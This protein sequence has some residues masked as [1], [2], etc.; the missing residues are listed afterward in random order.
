M[1]KLLKNITAFNNSPIIGKASAEIIKKGLEVFKDLPGFAS[2]AYFYL[3]PEDFDFSFG[4]SSGISEKESDKIF[5]NLVDDGGITQVINSGEI[6]NLESEIEKGE[7]TNHLVIPLIAASGIISL[8]L[9]QLE[10]PLTDTLTIDLCRMHAN[11]L[12][13]LLENKDLK[14]EAD[15]LKEITEQQVALKTKDIAQSTRELKIILDSVQAGIII[16]DKKKDLII[17][18]NMAASRLIGAGKEQIVGTPRKNYFF[19]IE[20]KSI[21]NKKYLDQ[22][23]LLK[24]YDGNLIPIIRTIKDIDA[25]NMKYTIES[26]MDISER[27]RMEDALSEARFELEQR[28]EERTQELLQVNND[29]QKE[30]NDRK[31]AEEQLLKLYWAVEQ[32]PI[33][34]IIT[35]LNGKIEYVNSH[36]SKM[37]Q[38]KFKDTMGNSFQKLNFSKNYENLNNEIWKK[39]AKGIEWRGEF[40]TRKK[41]GEPLWVSASASPIRNTEDK[42][43]HYLIVQ[44]D[45]SERK[46]VEQELLTAKEKAEQSD[47]LKSALLANMSHE[48][49]TPLIGILGFSQIL[50][51]QVEDKEQNE[52]VKEI[53]ISGKRLLNTLNGVLTISELETAEVSAE[54]VKTDLV[55]L[56]K[57]G[58]ESYLQSARA[59]G[60]EFIS[61]I[62]KNKIISEIDA[63]LFQQALNNIIDN[64][65]KY[66]DSG[67][68]SLEADEVILED[69][70]WAVIK[71]KDTGIGIPEND[72]EKIFEA[73]RQVSEG[74]TR[75]FEG[76]G[77]GLTISKKI[78]GMFGGNITLKSSQSSGSEFTVWLPVSIAERP[79]ITE[80]ENVRIDSGSKSLNGELTPKAR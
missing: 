39:L 59:K 27:K 24:T 51:D 33:S 61:A 15:S 8:I 35:D 1:D 40:Q 3:E 10:N 53:Q 17:D 12:A 45:I 62:K 29:L 70:V 57:S 56:L 13:V 20:K 54:C 80:G 66:T 43:T 38:Y 19:F 48:F 18:L 21:P 55:S 25:E 73:F 78:I 9:L 7:R 31:K 4:Y 46:R 52:M 44:E 50:T 26:F 34:I 16:A 11:Y 49:R 32:S 58:S 5:R 36:F 72:R 30:I 6:V 42:I 76:C 77:L 14:L 71:I 65:I 67:S 79:H 37:S 41:N 75:N 2:A 63:H 69:R 47:K 28:V 74:Y 22:E 68:V 60:L 23:G 64:A